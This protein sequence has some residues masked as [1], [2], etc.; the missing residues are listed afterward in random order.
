MIGARRPTVAGFYFD[1]VCRDVITRAGMDLAR[2]HDWLVIKG[3]LVDGFDSEQIN[4]A[5]D[6]C[7]SR[8]GYTPPGSLRY[9]DRAVRDPVTVRGHR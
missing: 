9:F 4:A 3:W 5:I 2:P 1:G 7:A 8:H 6:R